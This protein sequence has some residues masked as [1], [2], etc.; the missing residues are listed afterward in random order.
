MNF[1]Y[2]VFQIMMNLKISMM[3]CGCYLMNHLNSVMMNSLCPTFFSSEND[4]SYDHVYDELWSRQIHFQSRWTQ[5]MTAFQAQ[6]CAVYAWK[7]IGLSICPSAHSFYLS[8]SYSCCFVRALTGTWGVS[9]CLHF[10]NG[11]GHCLFGNSF[12][13]RHFLLQSLL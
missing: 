13:S 1:P 2:D 9:C 12:F 11:G 6:T 4:F 8:S 5:K 7:P 10:A 3:N